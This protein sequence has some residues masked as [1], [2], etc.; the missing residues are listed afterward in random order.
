[1]SFT[2]MQSEKV[3]PSIEDRNIGTNIIANNSRC[4]DYSYMNEHFDFGIIYIGTEPGLKYRDAAIAATR[5]L[6]SSGVVIGG[7]TYRKKKKRFIMTRKGDI[8]KICF[9]GYS[10]LKL[11]KTTLPFER[12]FQFIQPLVLGNALPALMTD[13]ICSRKKML[14]QWR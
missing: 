9:D 10:T 5:V 1:M 14:Q 7:F 11:V 8:E 6:D 4:I 2:R 13:K 12:N 3:E